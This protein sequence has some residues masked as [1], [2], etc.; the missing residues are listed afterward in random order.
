MR[1]RPPYKMAL[2]CLVALLLLLSGTLT[3]LAVAQ[4]ASVTYVLD[5]VVSGR[6]APYLVA[7]EKGFYR[8]RGIE[9]QIERGHG[10]AG[11]VKRVASGAAPFALA[12]TSSLVLA[13]A[14]ERVDARLVAMVYSNAPHALAYV[15]GKGIRG[16]KDLE[17][18]KIGATAGSSV[19]EIFPAFARAN[20][21]DASKVN[22]VLSDAALLPSLLLAGQVDAMISFLFEI[23]MIGR[24]AAPQGL[25]LA[26]MRYAD[27]GL[28]FYSSG[29]M[30][31]ATLIREN[32]DLVRRLTHAT[33]QGLL[34]AF[35]HPEEAVDLLR[36]RH[37]EVPREGAIPEVSMV[38][39]LAMSEGDKAHGIGYMS[40]EK[41]E[42]T[43]QLMTETYRLTVVVPLEDLYTNEFLPK[44]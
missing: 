30:T 20:G 6:H 19:R 42:S 34:Y 15:V 44:K 11:A 39:D 1:P 5:W 8:E 26:G 9:A 18:K 38:R 14:R 13:Q 36:R 3:S 28:K 12:D 32:P 31:K 24:K 43:R 33:L 4:M 27:Y 16:P 35:D 17:G 23:P 22:W 37:P 41:M 7:L 25:Q 10:S 29:V 21:V 2:L 40:K